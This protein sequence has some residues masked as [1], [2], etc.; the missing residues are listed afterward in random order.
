MMLVYVVT[1][2]AS[3]ISAAI[4]MSTS[5]L[6]TPP[7]ARASVAPKRPLP[8]AR[9]APAAPAVRISDPR[10][11]ARSVVSVIPVLP[12]VQ[13]DLVTL[14]APSG[15]RAGGRSGSRV[16][17][18]SFSGAGAARGRDRPSRPGSAAP[19]PDRGARRHPRRAS[20]G[21]GRPARGEHGARRR[22]LRRDRAAGQV[23]A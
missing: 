9:P 16:L 14:P 15:I 18:L 20:D 23:P 4:R 6:V 10:L 17:A 2:S 22:A 8:S 12:L 7:D 21:P 19:G 1:A 5:P 13:M 3:A 11:R